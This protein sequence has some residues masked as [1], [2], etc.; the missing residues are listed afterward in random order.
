MPDIDTRSRA[1]AAHRDGRAAMWGPAPLRAHEL[2]VTQ[3]AALG[4][5]DARLASEMLAD[6]AQAA[7]SGG[8]PGRAITTSRR[9]RQLGRTVGGRAEEMAELHHLVILLATGGR[10]PAKRSTWANIDRL[11]AL[12]SPGALEIL[13]HGATAMYWTEDYDAARR[14]LDRVVERARAA[15]SPIIA[16][17]L[18]TL[19][20]VLY[21]V[22]EWPAADGLSAEALRI[23]AER[24]VAFDTASAATTLARIAAARGIEGDCR[25]LLDRARRLAPRGSLAAAYAASAA[26]LLELSLG[27]ADAAIRAL[28]PLA[29][30]GAGNNLSPIVNQWLPELIESYVRAGR[31]TEA[32]PALARLEAAARTAHGSLIRA[33]AARS[34]GLLAPATTLDLHFGEALRLHGQTTVPFERARTE[35]CYG[36]RLRRARRRSEAAIHLRS[37]LAT[38]ERIGAT[39][40]ADRARRELGPLD[41]SARGAGG[42]TDLLTPHELA[43]AS[44]VRRGATNREAASALFVT[45]KT[46]EYHLA[47]IYRKLGVR[48]RT[49]LAIA[50]I[51]SETG[52]RT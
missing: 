19:A 17:A 29:T 18:D 22:G 24:A 46:I 52:H 51:G 12:D 43:V 13:L 6:A 48:S 39:P 36:E 3:A 30:G 37:A 9:A 1:R 4:A 16:T 21:R 2:L 34:R 33:L 14:L 31:A 25:A 15:R 8:E 50:L 11:A 23:A 26:G 27:R 38:F 47:A 40:W 5:R 41:R 10:R 42:V 35:L 20:A 7:I 32:F 28:E 44:L 49:E 45:P